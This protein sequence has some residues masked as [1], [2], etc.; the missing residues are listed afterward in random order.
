MGTTIHKVDLIA[1]KIIV[2]FDATMYD[3]TPEN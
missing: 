2:C 1:H 3:Q